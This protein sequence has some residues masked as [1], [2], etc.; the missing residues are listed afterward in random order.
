ML[1]CST[2]EAAQRLGISLPTLNKYIALKQIP[3]PPLTR[4]GGVK[5]RLWNEDDIQKVREIL[6]KIANGRKT[7]WEKQRKKM[8]KSKP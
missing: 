6:P 4:V 1:G 5:V 7:R 3:I 2:K 8:K